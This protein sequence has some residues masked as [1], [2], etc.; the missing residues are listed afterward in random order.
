[1]Q[2]SLPLTPVF[3]RAETVLLIYFIYAACIAQLLPVN[4]RAAR[5]VLATNAGILVAYATLGVIQPQSAAVSIVR[6]WVALLLTI[7]CYEEMGWLAPARH[8]HALEKRWII[9]DRWFLNDWGVKTA[10]ERWGSLF[11]SVLELSYALVYAMPAFGLV[12]LYAYGGGEQSDLFLWYFL[13]ATLPSYALFPYFPSEPPRTV[14]PEDDPPQFNTMFRRLNLWLL[15][16]TGIHTSVFPSA[17]V[18]GAFG[19]AFGILRVL[20]DH[21]GIGWGLFALACSITLATVYGRYHYFVDALAGIG[22]SLLAL[23]AA[24]LARE[25]R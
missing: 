1:M 7:L 15:G 9:W 14:F 12:T 19:V 16:R 21:S 18:S 17:H 4:R 20:P 25:A 22:I 5:R 3:R 8:T 23:F 24:S 2:A 6:D 11:P 13:L 10:I